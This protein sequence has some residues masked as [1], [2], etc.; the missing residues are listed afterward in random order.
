MPTFLLVPQADV[1]LMALADAALMASADADLLPTWGEA[2]VQNSGSNLSD[3]TSFLHE[4]LNDPM[5]SPV[6][7]CEIRL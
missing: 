2:T 4:L 1:A 6:H 5:K 3:R 7:R